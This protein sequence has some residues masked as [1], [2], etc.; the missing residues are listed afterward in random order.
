MAN[1]RR[2]NQ[3]PALT[4]H[5]RKVR[6][7]LKLS[8]AGGAFP[9]SWA[10]TRW[11]RLMEG[12]A[13]GATAAEGL[14]Y[15]RLGQTRT[16]AIEVGAV[17]ATIQGRAPRAYDTAIMLGA[18]SHDQ[19]EALIG[20]VTS[21]P[22]FAARLAS[23]D[24]PAALDEA[25]ARRGLALLPEP[26]AGLSVSCTCAA[27]ARSPG[28]WC[29][30]ACCAAY[31]AA[32]RIAADAFTLFTMRGMAREE[33]LERVRQR[34]ALAG[35]GAAGVPVYEPHVPG[36][37]DSPSHPLEE[38]VEQ[39]WDTPHPRGPELDLPLAPPDV[40][41]PLLRRLGPS[42]FAAPDGNGKPAATF[43]IVGL[44]AT[45]YET[46]SGAVIKDE[47]G[48]TPPGTDEAAD[49]PPRMDGEAGPL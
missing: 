22:V 18:F 27:G 38:S 44:L 39:F 17:R 49:A 15:A 4:L 5:P 6:G 46:I 24:V 40:S 32:E 12:A 31:L 29:K 48:E 14:Q 7:G 21:Q 3:R 34:R 28:A 25:L 20:F 47:S 8:R 30:H 36:A 13:D 1:D 10:A 19:W 9:E 16:L 26:P 43:P 42:P 2:V 33:L 35:A 11:L 37:S 41:H 23:A 45:C